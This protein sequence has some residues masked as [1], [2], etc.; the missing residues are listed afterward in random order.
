MNATEMLVTPDR[1]LHW[2]A[3]DM[4]RVPYQAY[5]DPQ[6]YALEQTRIFRGPFWNFLGLKAEVPAPGDFKSTTIGDTPV[7]LTRD[8]DGSLHAWVNRCS[9]RGGLVCRNSRGNSRD[10]TH[11]CVYHQW[12]FD[13]RGNLVGVP[14]RKGINGQGGYPSDFE[15]A[16]HG[17]QKLAIATI[18]ELVFASFSAAAPALDEYLGEE[19]CANIRRVFCRPIR[20]LGHARQHMKANW[21]LYADNTRDSY[22]GALLHLFYPTFNIYRQGQKGG[23]RVS[24]NELHSMMQVR[25]AE[26]DQDISEYQKTS[27]RKLDEQATL[28][29]PALLRHVREFD[30]VVA[31]I[32]SIFPNLVVQQIS[33][34]L[35][36]RQIVPLG[37]D[38]M[39][40]LWTYYGF[41]DD[42]ERMLE[43]RLQQANMVGPAG[44]ISMEDGEAVEIVQNA[45]AGDP[46]QAALVRMGGAATGS[47]T[48]MGVDENPI[49]GFW[50][51]YR[52]L[53]PS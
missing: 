27:S 18:E 31:T 23:V 13:N 33:N 48:T 29:D 8:K 32:Q 38:A 11:T 22:H 16:D 50:K 44:F 20:I 17:L 53:F 51:T 47:T 34:S 15:L 41:E 37:V 36:V 12:N 21:K 14:F 10:G 25:Q 24:P 46:G 30:D 7:V 1:G 3:A 4:T 49:R 26:A 9:H 52:T 28:R 35:C 39:E 45:I 19:M 5:L 43:H 40:L 2:P 42:D 6:L